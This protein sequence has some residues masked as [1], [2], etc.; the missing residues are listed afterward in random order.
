VDDWVL[1][2]LL[3]YDAEAADLEEEGDEEPHADDEED[4]PP[5]MPD[6]VRPKV[7]GR[8][9]TSSRASGQVG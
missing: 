2:R 7:S 8:K 6:L 5:V 9:R 3:T 4:G 1:V